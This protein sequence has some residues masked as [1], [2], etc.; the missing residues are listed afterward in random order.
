MASP[1]KVDYL[2]EVLKQ[3]QAKKTVKPDDAAKAL[4]QYHKIQEQVR[5]L[6]EEIQIFKDT[7]SKMVRTWVTRVLDILKVYM[8]TGSFVFCG[9]IM[10]ISCSKCFFLVWRS[11]EFCKRT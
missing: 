7:Q 1:T 4:T 9:R 8:T 5:A 6:K 11:I 10:Y 2:S 3:M